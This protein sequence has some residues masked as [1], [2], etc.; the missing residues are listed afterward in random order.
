MKSPITKKLGFK[1]TSSRLMYRPDWVRITS[2]LFYTINFDFFFFYEFQKNN[3]IFFFFF[4]FQIEKCLRKNLLQFGEIKEIRILNKNKFNFGF[5][6]VQFENGQFAK[7]EIL[8]TDDEAGVF[9]KVYSKEFCVSVPCDESKIPKQNSPLHI[10]NALRNDELR[11]IFDRL[12]LLEFGSIVNV[13]TK[14][15]VMAYKV[16]PLRLKRETVVLD[17]QKASL[18]QSMSKHLLCIENF[19]AIFGKWIT[20]IDLNLSKQKDETSCFYN[21]AVLLTIVTHCSGSNAKLRAL[22]TDGLTISSESKELWAPIFG[23]LEC[24]ELKNSLIHDLLLECN[25]LV[26]LRLFN[27]GV[28]SECAFV[29]MQHEHLRKL[30]VHAIDTEFLIELS[31]CLPKLQHLEQISININ[32][33]LTLSTFGDL[34]KSFPNELF[35]NVKFTCDSM[36]IWGDFFADFAEIL[37]TLRE[38]NGLNKYKISEKNREIQITSDIF[39]MEAVIGLEKEVV[40]ENNDLFQWYEDE[41]EEEN[42]N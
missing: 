30:D 39:T 37:K 25:K 40:Q 15:K 17:F 10:F 42:Q 22:K 23:R 13:C 28:G 33:F 3:W 19:F 26:N 21:K 4:S 36:Y 20:S 18:T 35:K 29:K 38:F 27:P 1:T 16:A 32:G 6:F 24:L 34:I 14:F 9:T 7:I 11:E 2:S 41:K 5:G 8:K 12:P 31:T